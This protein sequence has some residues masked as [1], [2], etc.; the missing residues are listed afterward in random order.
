MRAAL[1]Y[2]MINIGEERL[3]N[4]N[5]SMK[6][7]M[8]GNENVFRGVLLTVLSVIEY[9]DRP[10]ELYIGTMDLTDVD[11][12]YRP[13]TE[14]MTELL[15]S[16][17]KEKNPISEVHLID[18]GESFRRELIHSKNLTSSYTPYA[19]IRLFA[20]ELYPSVGDKLLYFDTDVMARGNIE[21][22]YDTD[23]GDYHLAGVRDY[24][25]KIF[26]GPR[27]LNSGVFLFNMK[28]MVDDGVFKKCRVLCNDKKML[29]FD[30]HALNKYAKRKLILNRRYN[31]QR[32]TSDK[33]LIRHFAM[34][35]RWLP[36]F[37]TENIKPWDRELVRGKLKDY[38]Y[39]EIYKKYDRIK[40]AADEKA[41]M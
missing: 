5:T 14:D 10:I 20:D 18:F 17:I 2:E 8:C 15:R 25:G 24:F 28:A 30:Q 36:Y 23:L 27:Y 16:V 11:G 1:R 34:T 7:L 37:R 12:R 19:M 6:I 4:N 38:S 26:F 29:L 13:I 33:T 31:E 21:E 9:T 41:T 39:E 32:K 35:I 22:L 40:E 3:V